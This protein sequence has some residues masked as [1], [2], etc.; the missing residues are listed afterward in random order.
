MCQLA[1]ETLRKEGDSAFAH[2]SVIEH[3]KLNGDV[4]KLWNAIESMT[5]KGGKT[6]CGSFEHADPRGQVHDQ[7]FSVLRTL[8][9][10]H[11][12]AGSPIRLVEISDAEGK[13][14]WNGLLSKKS[15][16][17]AQMLRSQAKNQRVSDE[18]FYMTIEDYAEQ[19]KYT[20]SVPTE[21]H[22]KGGVHKEG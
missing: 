12:A 3:Q 1:F 13:Q 4:D 14:K 8:T 16:K 19:I 5:K 2:S 17:W 20:V 21:S 18:M 22:A 10:P 6:T 11:A 15:H 7:A 9:L